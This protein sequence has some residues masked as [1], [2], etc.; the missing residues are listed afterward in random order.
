MGLINKPIIGFIGSISEYKLNYKLIHNVASSLKEINFV[1]IGPTDD[2]L[3]HSN[4][5]RIKNF[6]SEEENK[7]LDKLGDWKFSKSLNIFENA[8]A[9]L[10]LT[11]WEE[12]KNINWKEVSKKMVNPGWVFDARSI[13]EPDKISNAN[14]NFWRVGDGT[15]V[16]NNNL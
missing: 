10:L 7:S 9:V 16:I 5:N 13:I 6:S 8:H 12:Y 14:L 11:E 3:N 2:S 4:L 1:F 15:A